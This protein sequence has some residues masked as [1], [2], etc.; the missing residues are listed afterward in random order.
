MGISIIRTITSYIVGWALSLAIVQAVGLSEEQLTWLVLAVLTGAAPVLGS[1]WYA[2]R[3]ALERRW[4]RLGWL[5]GRPGAPSYS[6][7][8]RHEA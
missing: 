6:T 4:P 8:G 2:A 3:R 1:I 7:D 5:L